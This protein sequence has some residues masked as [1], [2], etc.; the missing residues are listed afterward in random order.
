MAISR[1]EFFV[2]DLGLLKTENDFKMFPYS[3]SV[4]RPAITTIIN[5][6]AIQK[7]KLKIAAW[8]FNKKMTTLH[9]IC[10]FRCLYGEH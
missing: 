1:K 9:L 8:N 3:F 10:L 4:T 7:A 2:K 6:I 5:P